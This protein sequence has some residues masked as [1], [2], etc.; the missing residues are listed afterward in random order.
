MYTVCTAR[1]K[2]LHEKQNVYSVGQL[3][4]L[5]TQTTVIKSAVSLTR[6]I[7]KLAG[8]TYKSTFFS[9]VDDITL[10]YVVSLVS[11]NSPQRTYV[12]T[13]HTETS[14][15][16][17]HCMYCKSELHTSASVDACSLNGRYK[18]TN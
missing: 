13:V 18:I 6:L 9:A 7:I 12:Y 16:Y 5:W 1:A 17:V 11:G 3:E 14:A 2:N 8:Q 4:G 10:Y 15:R